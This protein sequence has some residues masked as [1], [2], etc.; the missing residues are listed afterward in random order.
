MKIRERGFFTKLVVGSAR[1]YLDMP[2]KP[3]SRTLGKLYAKYINSGNDRSI[4]TKQ[5]D[6]INFELDL[7]EV[8]DYAMFTSGSREPDTSNALK[9]L[10]KRGNVVLDIGANVGSH[11]LPMASL[12]GEEGKVYAFE[13]VPWA[14]NRMKKNLELNNFKNMVL[15][16]IALSDT[17]EEMEMKFRASFKIGSKSGVGVEGKIDDGWWG[18]CEHIKVRL[19]TLDNYVSTR[20]FSHI[21]LIKLDVDGFEGKVIRGAQETLKQFTPVIIMEVAPAWTE[22]RGDNIKNILHDLE[23]FGYVFYKEVDFSPIKNIFEMIDALPSGG[24]M[25]ILAAVNEF[26]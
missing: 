20:H 9:V 6:G 13:P 7:R 22:M 17:N 12:V 25:N 15:E 1:M 24:G 3:F 5:I 2:V 26:K 23:S 21:D 4:V 19:Q 14:M 10:C 11:A 18:E 16:P 8:I